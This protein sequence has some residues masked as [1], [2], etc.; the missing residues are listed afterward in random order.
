MVKPNLLRSSMDLWA[1]A[2]EHEEMYCDNDERQY[3]LRLLSRQVPGED[4]ELVG[5]FLSYFDREVYSKGNTLWKQGTVSDSAKL[6]VC[7][8][9]MSVLENETG[10]TE[11]I[12]IG[13]MIGES[14][15]V[16]NLNRNSTV[17]VLKD[18][19]IL[20]SLCRESWENMNENDPKCARILYAIVVRYLTHRVQHVSNRIFETRCLPI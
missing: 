12:S 13:S 19:T 11:A 7:G 3:A 2:H 15:L 17:L 18:N 14:G 1:L 5:K 10:T 9:L 8:Q 4:G 6:L 16:Q 20:Y